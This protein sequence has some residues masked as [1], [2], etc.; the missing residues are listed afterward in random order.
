MQTNLFSHEEDCMTPWVDRFMY[1]S[2]ALQYFGDFIV[3]LLIA[4]S[5]IA[6]VILGFFLVA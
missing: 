6:L 2:T 5:G 4:T 3:N 1:P